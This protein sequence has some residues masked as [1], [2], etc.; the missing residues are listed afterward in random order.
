MDGVPLRDGFVDD[1]GRSGRFDQEE[2][3]AGVRAA[4]EFADDSAFGD[5]VVVISEKTNSFAWDFAIFDVYVS[6]TF[7]TLSVPLVSKQSFN[8]GEE[9]VTQ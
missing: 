2:S 9:T 6:H 1:H 7:Y 5:K 4:A 3:Q 8:A